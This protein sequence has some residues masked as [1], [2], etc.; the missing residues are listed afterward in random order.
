MPDLANPNNHFTDKAKDV[1]SVIKKVNDSDVVL[2]P[3][4]FREGNDT[5]SPTDRSY[6]GYSPN[7]DGGNRVVF[8]QI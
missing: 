7:N 4:F 5:T 1:I 2:V 8:V 6:Y 3:F